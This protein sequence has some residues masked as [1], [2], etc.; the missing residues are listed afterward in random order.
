M[1]VFL[2]RV[3]FCEVEPL[4]T[5]G[6]CIQRRRSGRKLPKATPM[7]GFPKMENLIGSVVGSEPRAKKKHY[8][9][10]Q[11]DDKMGLFLKKN[12]C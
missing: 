1:N 12:T 4:A 10:I 7:N 8:Y 2:L 6:L 11:K 5:K 9:F 3:P